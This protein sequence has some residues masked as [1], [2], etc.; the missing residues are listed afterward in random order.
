MFT[1]DAHIFLVLCATICYSACYRVMK[2]YSA[3]LPV[4]V[5]LLFVWFFSSF[6]NILRQSIAMVIVLFAYRKLKENKPK[7]GLLLILIASTFHRTSLCALLLFLRNF[8]SYKP[9]LVYPLSFF[10]VLS[11]MT[12]LWSNALYGILTLF[13]FQRAEYLYGI[14]SEGGW[15]GVSQ[16]VIMGGLYYYIAYSAYKKKC[17][18]H[19]LE[20]GV[21]LLYFLFSC[22]AF[23]MNQFLRISLYFQLIMVTELPNAIVSSKN[24]YRYPLM[25]GICSLNLLYFLVTLWLR[26]EW[27]H[28]YPYEFWG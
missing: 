7:S 26:P 10:L 14:Y 28:L 15:L 19:R 16:A 3:N 4:S 12:H 20:L 1:S 27:N 11:S 17:Q 8:F 9:R 24:R 5:C 13:H 21:F 23:A 25:L 22:T 18:E 6:N 2:R